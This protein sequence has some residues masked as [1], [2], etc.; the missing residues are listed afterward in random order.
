MKAIAFSVEEYE[1]PFLRDANHDQHELTLLP[2]R[3]SAGTA[4]KAA[5]YDAI[6]I[7]VK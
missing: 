5:G 1:E 6:L 2:D 4:D 7:F 3:L